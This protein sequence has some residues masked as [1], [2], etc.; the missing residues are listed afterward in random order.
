MRAWRLLSL[1]AATATF[2]TASNA[3]ASTPFA[4]VPQR[5]AAQTVVVRAGG[6]RLTLRAG[7][8]LRAGRERATLELGA[9]R[10]LR[11]P[12]VTVAAR[13]TLSALLGGRRQTVLTATGGRRTIDPVTGVVRLVGARGRLTREAASRLGL[14]AATARLDVD[15]DAGSD[16]APGGMIDWGLSRALRAA[17]TTSIPAPAAAI[18]VFDSAICATDPAR[19]AG[20]EPDLATPRSRSSIHFPVIDGSRRSVEGQGGL[21]IGALTIESPRL[22][23]TARRVTLRAFVSLDTGDPA[24]TV[25]Q[26]E[27]T[28]ATFAT[29]APV[30][31]GSMLAWTTGPG[32]PTAEAAA[33]LGADT[34]VDPLT[35]SID[36]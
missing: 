16:L 28:V 30:R 19:D 36:G 24:T 18:T 27:L 34:S 22:T 25:S 33:L 12:R 1:V 5:Q 32:T 3:V 31:R 9:T 8:L 14:P 4:D 6:K 10:A 21:R 26:R 13:T 2:A 17:A 29:G 35:F 23:V 15:A 11:E 20:C 7:E